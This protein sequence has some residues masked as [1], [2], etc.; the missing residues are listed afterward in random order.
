M[1]EGEA[2]PVSAK[3][4][5]RGGPSSDNGYKVGRGSSF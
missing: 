5:L 2:D 1:A 3:E 4:M